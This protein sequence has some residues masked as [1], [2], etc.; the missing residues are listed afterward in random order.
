[1]MEQRMLRPAVPSTSCACPLAGRPHPAE[2]GHGAVAA[3]GPT[4]RPA[5]GMAEPTPP[6]NTRARSRALPRSYE[7]ALPLN[8][9]GGRKGSS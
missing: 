8:L 1:M 5:R 9:D 4:F 3:A 7:G 6:R 2:P